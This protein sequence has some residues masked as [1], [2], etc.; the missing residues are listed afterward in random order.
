MIDFLVQ[1]YV[2]Y[3]GLFGW[4][5]WFGYISTVIFRPVVMIIIYSILGRFAGSPEIVRSYTIGIAAYMM[6]IIVLP[7]ITQCYVYDRFGGT[8]SFFF[9]SPANRLENFIAR[10]VLHYPNALISFIATLVTAWIMVGL[11]FSSVNWAGFITAV[12][13]TALSLTAMGEFLGTFAIIL[14]DWSTIQTTVVGIML[15]FSGVIIPLEIFPVA[16]REIAMLLPITNG[17]VTM[18]STFIGAPLSETSGFILREGLTG[19]V[20]FVTGYI[21]FVVFEYTARLSGTL[22]QETF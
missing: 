6:A 1:V 2:T 5:N 12:L 14:R 8:L 16:I 19:L 10:G 20:Y 22:E 18:R 9:A 15:V 17:L 21:S 3:R 7:G 4:L 13:I 11:D